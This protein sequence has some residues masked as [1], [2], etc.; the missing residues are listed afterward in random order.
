MKLPLVVFRFFF[1]NYWREVDIRQD[2]SD[3]LF[4]EGTGG[5]H[6]WR[7]AKP[8][9]PKSSDGQFTNSRHSPVA[10]VVI[11]PNALQ[12]RGRTSDG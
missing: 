10:G 7:P 2:G 3:P 1:G 11:S 8:S 9:S 6:C 12:T 5:D 4:F